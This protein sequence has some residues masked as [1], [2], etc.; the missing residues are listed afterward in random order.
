MARLCGEWELAGDPTNFSLKSEESKALS[1]GSYITDSV[2]VYVRAL[3][4]PKHHPHTRAS[5]PPPAR[6]AGSVPTGL[7]L[8]IS[9]RHGGRV[10]SQP[11]PP[12]AAR[13]ATLQLLV[14][15]LRL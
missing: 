11:Q 13:P 12:S 10:S 6:S 3:C 1:K 5:P 8:A 7:P 2:R 4:L 15:P 14:R 9:T